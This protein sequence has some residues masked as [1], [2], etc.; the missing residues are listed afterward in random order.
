V[1]D[2]HS[3][4]RATIDDRAAVQDL[5]V[6]NKMFARDELDEFNEAF[7]GALD[8]RRPDRQWWVVSTPDSRVIAA[9]YVAPEPYS[10]RLWNLFFLAV[11]PDQHGSGAG[12]SLI[13]HVE[14]VLRASGED[15]ARVL[16][17]ET[18]STDQY[19]A[20]RAFYR[21]RGFDE[22]ARIREFYGPGDHKVV[23]WKALT[24]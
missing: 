11:D 20:T 15:V 17:V 5:A 18:S 2:D 8:G 6:V 21:A 4:R 13:G 12:T 1:N 16:I 10:D 9:A 14:D 22:A 19:A 24:T 23:F 3:I 7:D